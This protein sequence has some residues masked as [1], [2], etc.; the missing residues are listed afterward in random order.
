MALSPRRYTQQEIDNL[1]ACPKVVSEPPKRDMKLDRGHFRK[2]MR[3]KSTDDKLEFRVFMRRS[4]DLPENFSI[5]LAF[6][7]KDGSGELILLR[8]NEPHGGYNDAFDPGH[9]HW[10]YHVHRASAEMIDAGLRPEKAATANMDFASYEE[11]EQYFL[12]ATNVIDARTYF[13]DLAQGILPFP[14]EETTR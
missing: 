10:D 6:L 3:V 14:D 2:D 5:G 9:P 11:A 1:I 12:R 7:A 4:Q 13:G 8:C